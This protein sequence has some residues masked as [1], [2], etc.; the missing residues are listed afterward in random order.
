MGVQ[1]GL[2]RP[3]ER[4]NRTGATGRSEGTLEH[5]V[6]DRRG[7]CEILRYD[8]APGLTERSQDT[9]ASAACGDVR[10]S[11]IQKAL[12]LACDVL[13]IGYGVLLSQIV[14]SGLKYFL[15]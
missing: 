8:T 15:C 7:Q 5:F 13:G 12:Y 3:G 2:L 10:L 11:K 14:P 9:R 6:W 4:R 1:G